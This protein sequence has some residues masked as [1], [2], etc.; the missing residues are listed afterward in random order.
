MAKG[1]ATPRKRRGRPPLPPKKGKRYPLSLRTT[2]ELQEL[3]HQASDRTGRSIAQEVEFRLEQSFRDDDKVLSLF[4]LAYGRQNAG[5]LVLLGCALAY[6]SAHRAYYK[7]PD[8][9]NDHVGFDVV[10]GALNEILGKLRPGG[11]TKYQV[12]LKERPEFINERARRLAAAVEWT[13]IS[14][15]DAHGA[16]KML[17]ET[18]RDRVSARTVTRPEDLVWPP[19]PKSGGGDR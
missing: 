6:A 3:L 1:N 4:E 10:A 5:V 12:D 7:E 15:D 16:A 19:E 2:K 9:L 8:W 11:E 18:I 14:D 13:F 17:G